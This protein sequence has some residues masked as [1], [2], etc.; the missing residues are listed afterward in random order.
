M[1]DWL[2]VRRG[3]ERVASAGKSVRQYQYVV[4]LTLGLLI[5]LPVSVF[6]VEQ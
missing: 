6:C 5:V 2:V 1:P 4:Q 3:R